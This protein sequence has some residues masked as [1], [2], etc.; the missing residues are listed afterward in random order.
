MMKTLGDR[1]KFLRQR[2]GSSVAEVAEFIEVGPSTYRDWEYG[3]KIN[4]EPYILLARYFEVSLSF[5]LTGK[6]IEIDLIL[7]Q[8]EEHVKSIRT[9][10]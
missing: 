3:R 7:N 9:S 8:I 10:L 1:L 2:K 4:G 6:V 5:L